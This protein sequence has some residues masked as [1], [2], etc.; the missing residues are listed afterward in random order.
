MQSRFR[1][2]LL[3]LA[4]GDALGA[5]VE[6][7]TPGSFPPLTD[8][9]GGGPFKL[10][11]G[12]WTDD[13]SMALCLATSLLEKRGFDPLDQMQRY[14]RWQEEGY[15]SSTGRCFDIGFTSAAALQRFRETG[16]PFCGSTDPLTSG[17]GSL[18][19][20]APIPMYYVDNLRLVAHY[21]AESSRTTHASLEAVDACRLFGVMVALALRGESKETILLSG[22]RRVFPKRKLAAPI[23]EIANGCYLQKTKDEIIA[24]GYV[25]NTLEAALW[26]FWQTETFR[27]ALLC[28]ANLGYDADTTSAVTGQIAGAFYG[29]DKIPTSWLTFV[30]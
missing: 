17:N 23:E 22:H 20:L 21:A 6:F 13:T 11:A 8:M 28:A 18:M 16:E 24:K 30:P 12:D 29:V 27:D 3:G 4:C 5:A 19:R 10:R 15:L 9:E 25:V 7:Q 26:S 1:G 14:C 2:C